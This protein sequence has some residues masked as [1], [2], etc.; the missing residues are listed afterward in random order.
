MGEIFVIDESKNGQ[1][2]GWYIK[3]GNQKKIVDKSKIIVKMYY[4]V[5][6]KLKKRRKYKI[7][8]QGHNPVNHKS[9][10]NNSVKKW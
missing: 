6:I 5:K 7:E 4:K 2:C 3:K 1:I 10:P 8:E 9:E